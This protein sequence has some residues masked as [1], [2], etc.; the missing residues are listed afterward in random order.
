M[1]RTEA[2]T[3]RIQNSFAVRSNAPFVVS[4]IVWCLRKRAI[5]LAPVSCP[6]NDMQMCVEGQCNGHY[7]RMDMHTKSSVGEHVERPIARSGSRCENRTKEV[8]RRAQGV[9]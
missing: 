7:R 4:C 2:R 8:G 3:S 9:T 6:E 5:A 1:P